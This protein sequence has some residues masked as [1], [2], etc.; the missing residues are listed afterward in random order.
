[1]EKTGLVNKIARSI[2]RNWKTYQLVLESEE[3]KKHS[4]AQNVTLALLKEVKSTR[5]IHLA[6]GIEEM[7]LR[8]EL[9][10]YTN[11]PEQHNSI[12]TAIEQLQDAKVSLDV[13][14]T[15]QQYRI[16]TATY[17]ASQKESGLPVDS[18]R[19]FLKS[20]STR[21]T[22]RMASVLFAPEKELLRQRKEN[23][24]TVKELYIALQRK[25]L[26]VSEA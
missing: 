6:L 7:L 16:A 14:K 9:A 18:F 20:H 17:P 19:A 8:Q 11:S 21:L 26:G 15:P 4:E 1:M 24:V 23:L 22:N 12:T 2:D 13:V 25:A 3:E 5:D 10:V